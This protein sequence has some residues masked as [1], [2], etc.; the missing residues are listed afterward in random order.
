MA[1]NL[2]PSKFCYKLEL[3]TIVMMF[4][5][6]TKFNALYHNAPTFGLLNNTIIE[7]KTEQNKENKIK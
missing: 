4:P 2:F 1:N 6:I 7:R 5:K 3:K